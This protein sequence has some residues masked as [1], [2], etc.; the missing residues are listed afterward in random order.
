MMM[1]YKYIILKMESE[2]LRFTEKSVIDESA[3][4]YEF[5]K[6][7]P[8]ART[9]LNS[10]GEINIEPQDLIT[11]PCENKIILSLKVV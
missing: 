1:I 11:H 5:H 6:Y 10:P 2:I 8:Q 3:Q 9:Y 7:E 4:E